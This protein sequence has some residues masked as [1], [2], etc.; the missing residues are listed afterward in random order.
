MGAKLNNL[1]EILVITTQH[2]LTADATNDT[3]VDTSAYDGALGFILDATNR[4]GTTPTLAVKLQHS[5]DNG[6]DDAFADITDGAFT[7]L[8]NAA[9]LPQV[10]TLERNKVKKYVKTTRDIGGTS[11]PEYDVSVLMMAH[12]KYP[13]A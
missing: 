8:T 13:A 2:R 11:S 10:I 12:R 9:H 1:P 3:G 5:D 6:V 4:A 7:G